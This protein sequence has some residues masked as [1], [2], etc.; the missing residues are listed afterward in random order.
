MGDEWNNENTAISVWGVIAV[1]LAMIAV[2]ACL[3]ALCATDAH[4]QTGPR[5]PLSPLSPLPSDPR[6]GDGVT[7][8]VTV[9]SVEAGDGPTAL[10]A[11][12]GILL[13]IVAVAVLVWCAIDRRRRGQ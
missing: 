9:T 11:G 3:I 7:T 6:S 13:A 12:I 1:A 8:S 4:A 2:M 10:E 5:S